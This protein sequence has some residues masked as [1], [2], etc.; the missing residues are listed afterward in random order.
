MQKGQVGAMWKSILSTE[1][2]T[3]LNIY[4]EGSQGSG[5]A[6]KDFYWALASHSNRESTKIIQGEFVK[7]TFPEIGVFKCPAACWGHQSRALLVFNQGQ[8]QPGTS[9]NIH[10]IFCV[11]QELV[12]SVVETYNQI[13]NYV[14]GNKKMCILQCVL[15]KGSSIL[16]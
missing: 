4:P 6:F 7:W 12:C 10:S 8:L 11:R 1:I 9:G 2:L 13:F 16:Y 14:N 5:K 15:G 3:E